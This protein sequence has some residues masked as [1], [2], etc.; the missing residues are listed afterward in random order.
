MK[1]FLLSLILLFVSLA[2]QAQEP[3]RVEVFGGYSYLRGDLGDVSPNT[4]GV[5]G[6]VTYNFDR[7]LGVKAEFG[8]Q[9]GSLNVS[10]PVNNAPPGTTTQFD[11]RPSYFT[12]LFG[13]QFTYRKSQRITP[14]AHVLLGG[15]RLKLRVPQ[16]AIQFPLPGVTP[17]PNLALAPSVNFITGT[18]TAFG[19]AVGGG[20]DIRLSKL[21]AFRLFQ[22]DYLLSRLSP[23]TQ[24]NLR[25][26]TGLV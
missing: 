14:F 5:L 17:P 25:L 18:N 21:V 4:N 16:A 24:N 12:F 13:P 15:V 2:A 10:A 20:M 19:V 8:G 22:A 23:G 6:S 11:V 3:P 7:V 1:Y 26:S 9:T